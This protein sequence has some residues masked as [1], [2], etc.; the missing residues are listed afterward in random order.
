MTDTHAP[1]PDGIAA[2][3]DGRAAAGD[4]NDPHHLP[5]APNEAGRPFAGPCTRPLAAPP[6]H[7]RDLA[8]RPHPGRDLARAIAP[9]RRHLVVADAPAA[10]ARQ[11][12]ARGLAVP[13]QVLGGHQ[14]ID[15][16]RV[17]PAVGVDARAQHHDGV[18]GRRVRDRA[19]ERRR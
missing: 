19:H 2:L 5:Q 4:G 8:P 13:P 12:D 6:R 18:A 3:A 1:S 16:Q 11:H 7:R 9:H 17:R 14:A 10:E 15:Q